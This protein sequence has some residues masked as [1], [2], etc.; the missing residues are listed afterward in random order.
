[1]PQFNDMIL[2]PILIKG[3]SKGTYETFKDYGWQVVTLLNSTGGAIGTYLTPS[4]AREKIDVGA[5]MFSNGY[6]G[7]EFPIV[8]S[9]PDVMNDATGNY[10]G[11]VS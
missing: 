5:R 2:R 6:I 7:R 10:P 9:H 1:M 11:T 8:R 3:P 4:G